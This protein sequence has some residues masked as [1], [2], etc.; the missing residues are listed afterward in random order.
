MPLSN[1]PCKLP[2]KETS[3]SLAMVLTRLSW[4]HGMGST[5]ASHTLGGHVCLKGKG[6]KLRSRQN[7]LDQKGHRLAEPT[8]TA[9]SAFNQNR[10]PRP[11]LLYSLAQQ[12]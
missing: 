4:P 11:R 10:I 1:V 5:L 3:T 7:G 6:A 8:H 2:A 12:H 9:T